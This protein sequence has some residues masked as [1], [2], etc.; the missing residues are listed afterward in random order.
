[1]DYEYVEWYV[2]LA[3]DFFSQICELCPNPGGIFKET[4]A[5]KY[6]YLKYGSLKWYG[7][8]NIEHCV[9]EIGPLTFSDGCTWSVHCIPL[10]WH[11][12]MLINSVLLL[13]LRCLTQDGEQG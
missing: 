6:E 3:T 5:G 1:M 12:E 11:S 7:D 13:C 9:Y 2:Q 4:D 10:G 8:D